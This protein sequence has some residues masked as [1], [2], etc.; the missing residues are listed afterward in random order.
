MAQRQ[1]HALVCCLQK[2]E[3]SLT[4]VANTVAYDC[5]EYL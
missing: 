3:V 4:I 5:L 2:P 1:S